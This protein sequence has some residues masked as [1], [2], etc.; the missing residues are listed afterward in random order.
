[1]KKTIIITGVTGAIGGATALN[2]ANTNATIILMARNE[3]K[4]Q[5][6]QKDLISKTG[7]VNINYIV[8][9]LA[10]IDSVKSAIATF[11]QKYAQLDVLINIAGVYNKNKIITKDGLEEMFAINHL[12]P[13]IL[14]NGL[15][16][17]LQ[18]SKGRIVTVSAPSTTKIDFNNLQAEKKFSALTAFGTSKAMNLLFTYQFAK[19]Y[20]NSGITATVLHPGVVKSN[21]TNDM[22]SILK[23]I[24]GLLASSP[25]KSATMLASLALDEKYTNTTGKFYKYDGKEL[26]SNKASYDENMQQELWAVSEKLSK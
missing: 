1:M 20:A 10:S 16:D 17:M 13:F 6:L 3:S 24:F 5:L 2:I 25:D 4:L 7:N 26:K 9:D 21:I 22:P 19:K 18:K 14:S 8:V 12:A 11:K 23:L 15:A